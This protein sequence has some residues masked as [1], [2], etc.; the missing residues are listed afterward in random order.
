MEESRPLSDRLNALPLGQLLLMQ[1]VLGSLPDEK[2]IFGFVCRG[3]TDI[4]GVAEAR[5]SVA[6]G[7][8]ID[9]EYIR[10]PLHVGIAK[11]GDLLIRVSD[12]SAF[13]P[14]EP[15][16]KNFSLMVA[17]ILRER[18]LRRVNESHAAEL[19][20]RV[21]ERTSALT[22][23][24]I[25][26]KR[27]EEIIRLQTQAAEKQ[28]TEFQAILDAAPV[29]VA[30]KSNDD[31]FV[32]VNE[33]FAEF[34]GLP[35]EKIIGMTTF[36]VVKQ[37][38]VATR[39]R[40]QDL[41]VIR[42]GLPVNNQLVKWSGVQSKEEKWGIYSKL[43]ISGADGDIIGTVSFVID[44]DTRVRAETALRESEDRY[45][46]LVEHSQDLIC[47][48]DLKGR[49]LSANPWAARLLGY[50]QDELLR[51]NLRDLIAPEVRDEFEGYLETIRKHGT[52]R[53]MLRVQTRN[54]EQLIWEYNNTLRT[55][56][57]SEPIVRGMA[58]DVTERMRAGKALREITR[59]L[60]LA[61]TS[62]GLGIWEWDIQ[63]NAL[64][65]DDRMFELYGIP[66]DTSLKGVE[67]WKK[68][69]HPDDFDAAME[70]SQ[71]AI[72]GEKEYD[73]EFRVLLP[74]GR[75][76]SLQANAIVIRDADGKAL[77]MIG[78]NSDITDRN[79]AEVEKEKL[80]SQLQQ[81]MKMEAV[82]RLAGGIAHDFNNL[83]TAIIG[84]VSLAMMKLSPSDPSAGMLGEAK[85]ASERA[86]RLTQ[87]LLA[88]SRKQ[89]IEPKILD[90]NDLIAGLKT[91][92]AR[93]IGENI[94]LRAIPGVDLGLVKVDP[95][96]IEQILM[97][98]AV[99]ARDAMPDGGKLIIETSNAD[100]DAGYC[101]RHPDASPGRFVMLAVTDT[102]HGMSDEIRKHIFEPF[103]TTKPKGSGTG[104]G[105]S[106]IY[107]AVR[108]SGG[109]IEVSSEEGK[110]TK[111]KIFLPRIEG[112]VP[113]PEMDN[114][115]MDL[116]EGYETVL[117]VE[118]EETVRGL[119]VKL[120][121]RLGY[122]V[123]QA[124]NGD[125]AIALARE[126][127]KRIDLLLTDVVMP[128][129][130]GREL[131]ERLVVLHPETKVLFTSG[132]TD[133]AIVHHGVLDE[134]V[135]FI[136][137]PYTLSELANKIREVLD[138]P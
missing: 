43:P 117:V 18:D 51:M 63:R 49:L 38:E 69:L 108:Q 137:K 111:F 44:V 12:M 42:T 90:L 136:G 48:H 87:Q 67:R 116:P 135:A 138:S 126:H 121:E 80:Q 99:N 70:A 64:H 32:W 73:P 66:R 27:A 113:K 82:G 124:S 110:E 35:R 45:R 131:A 62:A 7:E 65:W 76:R 52:A 81:A 3:L 92:L 96:Q 26:R 93:L 123:L 101:A 40:D 37:P 41:E 56:G 129:M 19:E 15:Y 119:C 115:P 2:S 57:V 77:R 22:E 125:E 9:K 30:Y 84:N 33:A 132:Y 105:L 28:R 8:I 91:M 114:G 130:N 31:H 109:S 20:K 21:E 85:K 89:I 98:L 100:L 78:I 11:Y 133:D 97:N 71:A 14:Y 68:C 118:D 88:F 46:D 54:G 23:E 107:G 13:M 75:V 127:V 122:T 104:L 5:F 61:A 112:E 86:A 24:I 1:S 128:G 34:V 103:F 6:P 25:D 16:L 55:E 29:M 17:V 10:Y 106:T 36:D 59:R 53:G 4:P 134:G 47:T 83:L 102:G 95:G 39:G 72:R 79:N 94:E 50:S 74:D 58:Q 60:Q 120:L